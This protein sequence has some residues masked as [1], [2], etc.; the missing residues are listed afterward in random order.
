[1]LQISRISK[2][3]R[4]A[5][6]M[7][8]AATGG[9]LGFNSFLAN[10]VGGTE[11]QQFMAGV[12]MLIAGWRLGATNRLSAY[13]VLF[14]WYFG[15][16]LTA[17]PSGMAMFFGATP[18]WSW[19]GFAAWASTLAAPALLFPARFA[20]L[21][22]AG[23]SLVIA[24]TPLGAVNPILAATAFFPSSGWVGLILAAGLLAFPFIKNE[25]AFVL[26]LVG[27]SLAG[28]LLTRLP[29]PAPAAAWAIDTHDGK[30]PTLVNE[31]FGKQ[32]R[33]S[34]E[35]RAS[36][37]AGTK[38]TV[39]PEGTVDAWDVWSQIAWRDAA[40]AAKDKNAMLLVGAYRQMDNGERQNGLIDPN[41]GAFY[42]ATLPMPL[43]M[44]KP[45][46]KSWH[47]PVDATQLVRTI[48]TP[49]GEAAYVICYEEMLLWPLA[50]KVA[51]GDPALVISAANQWFATTEASVAQTRSIR[52]QAR[53]WGLPLVRAVNWPR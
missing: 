20:G 1:M 37:E 30:I 15:A 41:T 44:W 26:G 28:S 34:R 7:A 23:A 40:A 6:G 9:W 27:A 2:H 8:L 3:G 45:W 49:A 35:A 12:L 29:P 52:L 39:T 46:D 51:A 32:A 24:A 47:Y 11:A 48:P 53:L 10:E 14:A 16:G 18:F 50:S 19:T 5:A 17:F 42:G 4:T 38:L 31:W 21:A 22:L 43:A 33:V 25:R 36:I 13:A